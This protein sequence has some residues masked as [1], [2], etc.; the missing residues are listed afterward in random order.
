M[1]IKDHKTELRKRMLQERDAFLLS[2]K[3]Q[4]DAAICEKLKT[5]IQQRKPKT[6]HSYLPMG[7]EVNVLPVLQYLLA[8]KITVVCPKSLPK[9]KMENR[10]LH[11]LDELENGIF[12][13]KHPATEIVHE[14]AIDMFIV[15]GLAFDKSG[16]RIGYGAGYYDQ[17]F[18]RHPHGY[19]VGV[20]Y[21][22]QICKNLPHEEYDVIM[23]EVVG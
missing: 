13:T 18:A 1:N 8:Q 17:F 6:V 21:P 12:G 4:F 9:G 10:I 16:N 2:D 23:D 20:C 11:S 22:F 14:D 15:P 3:N 5:L 7:S 19:K